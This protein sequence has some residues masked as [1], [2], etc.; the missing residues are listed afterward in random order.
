MKD[1]IEKLNEYAYKGEIVSTVES[2]K[3]KFFLGNISLYKLT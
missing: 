2:L 3:L 1:I